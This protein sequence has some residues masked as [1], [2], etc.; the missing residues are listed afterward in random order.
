MLV[1]LAWHC[2]AIETHPSL[3]KGHFDAITV[4]RLDISDS[5]AMSP[6]NQSN[7]W[8]SKVWRWKQTLG[9]VQYGPCAD[10]D[11]YHYLPGNRYEIYTY[12]FR[13]MP[14]LFPYPVPLSNDFLRMAKKYRILSDAL[15]TVLNH[16]PILCSF[17]YITH[18]LSFKKQACQDIQ[19]IVE[20]VRT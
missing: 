14:V 4:W 17:I 15:S 16:L 3:K 8:V 20:K 11:E 12:Y 1:Q 2:S 7:T 19:D 18:L 5:T 13:L 10:N 6:R 9:M